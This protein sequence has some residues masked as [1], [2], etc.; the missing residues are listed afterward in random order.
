MRTFG[1]K[2]RREPEKNA[3]DFTSCPGISLNVCVCV[4]TFY[5]EGTH[6]RVVGES[7]GFLHGRD[8]QLSIYMRAHIL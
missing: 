4:T 7:R 2:G 5:F 3:N 6:V 8:E 1:E